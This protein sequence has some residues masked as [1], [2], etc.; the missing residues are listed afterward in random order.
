MSYTVETSL[1]CDGCGE[2][3][4]VADDDQ[5]KKIAVNKARALAKREG[6]LYL[7]DAGVD[8]CGRCKQQ[9]QED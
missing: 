8:L 5:Q 2:H 7:K 3:I 9:N 6:W 1:F 4:V